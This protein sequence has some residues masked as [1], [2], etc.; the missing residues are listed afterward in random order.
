MAAMQAS[1]NAA[2]IRTCEARKRLANCIQKSSKQM[3]SENCSFRQ[4]HWQSLRQ[5][6]IIA[7]Y[8]TETGLVLKSWSGGWHQGTLE[9]SHQASK[10]PGACGLVRSS[11][12]SPL[13]P[14]ARKPSC[15]IGS[16]QFPQ[17]IARL[18][19]ASRHPFSPVVFVAG[20]DPGH[21]PLRG[22][23]TLTS[24]RAR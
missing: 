18:P 23:L 24:K 13:G 11:R 17:G 8:V 20:S 15:G 21:L 2:M 9:V 5:I 3:S 12:F 1:D 10:R 14:P 16:D 19:H 4:D 6:T 22:R 7:R